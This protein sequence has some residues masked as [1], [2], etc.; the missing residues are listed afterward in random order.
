[1]TKCLLTFQR[2]AELA[3]IMVGRS[4]SVL[5]VEVPIQWWLHPRE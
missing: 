4:D 1:M 3:G 2:A 5:R